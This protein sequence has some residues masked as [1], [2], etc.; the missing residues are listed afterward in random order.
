MT[1]DTDKLDRERARGHN[2][3]ALLESPLWIEARNAIRTKLMD[4]WKASPVRD[5]EARERIWMMTRIADLYEQHIRSFAE[6]GRLASKQLVDLG[7]R[8]KILGII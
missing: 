4:E 6:T 2:A 3:E 5:T 8:K 1:A 7:E